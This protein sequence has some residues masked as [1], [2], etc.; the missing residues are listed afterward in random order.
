MTVESVDLR[1]ATAEVL[2][3]GDATAGG[4]TLIRYTAPPR[5]VGGPRHRHAVTAEAF[6]VLAGTLT[7]ELDDATLT[8]GAGETVAAPPGAV[9]AFR[10]DGDLPATFLVVATPPGLDRF[11]VELSAVIA[12]SST[13]PP[14]D[15][16][17]L[18][19][20]CAQYDQL[21]PP[22]APRTAN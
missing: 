12:G 22:V 5:F 8:L 11:L 18:D 3:R 1:G 13:W 15:R 16:S 17:A 2:V 20:L 6:H 19:D 4:F 10:N 14:R 21:L 9:H 7:V